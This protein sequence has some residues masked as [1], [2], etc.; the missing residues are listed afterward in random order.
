MKLFRL[1]LL[2]CASLC[3]A[4]SASAS[5]STS[6][7]TVLQEYLPSA[8]ASDLVPGADGFGAVRDD[9]AAAPVL[10]GGETVAWVFITSDF[11]GTTGYSGKPIHTLVA[12][13]TDAKIISVQLVKHSEPIDFL[14]ARDAGSKADRRLATPI[15]TLRRRSTLPNGQL[16]Y[17]ATPWPRWHCLR[18]FWV[19]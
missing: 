12:V 11:V 1:F 19:T 16:G 5:T 14:A 9:I 4:V 8:K 6:T 17:S 2:L 10:K 7:S 18:A 13:G 15:L 3:V